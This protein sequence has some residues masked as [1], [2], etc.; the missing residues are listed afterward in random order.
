MIQDRMPPLLLYR[1]KPGGKPLDTE[2]SSAFTI[3]SFCTEPNKADT[4]LM[5]VFVAFKHCRGEAGAY[6]LRPL[7]PGLSPSFRIEQ[8]GGRGVTPWS[9]MP[10]S[11]L[12][13]PVMG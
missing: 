13:E 2:R 7:V 9:G 8:I 5:L 6:Q 10:R 4:H 1:T 3:G 11:F 12:I